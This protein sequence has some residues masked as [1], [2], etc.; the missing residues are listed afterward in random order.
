MQWTKYVLAAAVAA[1]GLAG[2]AE[3]QAEAVLAAI[4]MYEREEFKGAADAFR[5]LAD[6]GEP[7]AMYWLSELYSRG[8]GVE[9]SHVKAVYWARQAAERGL[10]EAQLSIGQHYW[11]GGF[12]PRDLAE[13]LKWLCAAYKG[14][15]GDVAGMLERHYGSPIQQIC[16]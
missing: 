1:F 8:K 11:F 15:E 10:V 5:Q 2:A 14:G 9:V 7:R 3:G 4:K 13:G 6:A 16:P 12:V